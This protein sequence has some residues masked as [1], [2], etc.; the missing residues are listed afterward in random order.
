LHQVEAT[1]SCYCYDGYTFYSR[2]PKQAP[3]Q[4]P[5]RAKGSDLMQSEILAHRKA[6]QQT[7]SKALFHAEQ[8]AQLVAPEATDADDLSSVPTEDRLPVAC[9]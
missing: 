5:N 2:T 7:L 9:P 6:I 1:D 4:P 8:L 3:T